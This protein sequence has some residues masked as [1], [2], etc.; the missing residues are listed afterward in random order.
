M[1][2]NSL[3]FIAFASLFTLLFYGVNEKIRPW[4]LLAGSLFFYG[5]FSI[6][7][8][9]VLSMIVLLFF[10]GGRWIERKEGTRR[11]PALILLVTSAVVL[12]IMARVIPYFFNSSGREVTSAAGVFRFSPSWFIPVGISYIVF[13]GISYLVDVKRGKCTAT[14]N[15]LLFFNFFLY[16]PKVTQGPIERP[17]IA[18]SRYERFRN[19]GYQSIADGLKLFAWGLFKKV[20]IADRLSTIVGTVYSSPTEY[21]G[22]VLLV[23]TLAFA[24]QIYADFSG[25]TDMAIG[26]SMML[27]IELAQNFNRPYF[28]QSIR[29]FW[30]RW[31][32]TLSNWLRDYIFLPLAYRFSARLKKERYAG[33]KSE[34]WIYLSATLLT[35]AICGLWHGFGWNFLLWGLLFG[36]YL[37]VEMFLT[38]PR[39]RIYRRLHFKKGH[40]FYAL[41]HTTLAFFLVTL[42]WVLFRSSTP[43]EA[44][45]IYNAIFSIPN[46]IPDFI[47]EP[48]ML[49]AA[50]SGLGVSSRDMFFNLLL[51]LFLF[52]V[53]KIQGD[54][55]FADRLN[56]LPSPARWTFY[57]LLLVMLLL[58]GAYN[59]NQDFIYAQF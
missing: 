36:V 40:W 23:A 48:G 28:S 13:S 31:H 52:G 20:V 38:A 39:K 17:T 12:L 47:T 50:L 32:I 54:R 19:P 10:A 29:E 11:G 7:A 2:F 42:G 56:T 8:L 57:Y 14:N 15:P 44:L 6:P 4:L 51:V 24:I 45:H 3:L 37:S 30:S 1:Q 55:R 21:Q 22:I 49:K 41:L 35:F 33:I 59:V 18:L 58:L 53:E 43:R 16:F 34:Q 25:Y 5:F 26:F 27:G 46:S 9:V